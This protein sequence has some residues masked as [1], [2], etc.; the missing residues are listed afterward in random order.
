MMTGSHAP[1]DRRGRRQAATTRK[2]CGSPGDDPLE[3][4][5]ARLAAFW[6]LVL[7]RF[8]DYAR[9][10]HPAARPEGTVRRTDE[11]RSLVG[12]QPRLGDGGDGTAALARYPC[13]IMPRRYIAWP[14][15]WRSSEITLTSRTARVTGGSQE[16]S[17]IRGRSASVRT[18]TNRIVGSCTAS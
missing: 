2:A 8:H 14:A 3:V 6:A 7:R 15:C 1:D 9:T 10:S 16:S 5:R 18:V 11:A 17:T 4:R 13:S 12:K